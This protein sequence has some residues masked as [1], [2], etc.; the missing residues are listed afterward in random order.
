MSID[1]ISIKKLWSQSAGLCAFPECKE[2]CVKFLDKGSYII[3]EMAHV[4]ARKED[5]PRG[6]AGG[7]EDNYENLILL[8]PTH[9]TMIDKS[10]AGTFTVDQIHLWKKEHELFVKQRL[11]IPLLRNKQELLNYIAKKLIENKS[12]WQQYGPESETAILNPFSNLSEYWDFIKL[13]K[14][15]PNNSMIKNAI[16]TYESFFNAEEYLIS[17][18]FIIH[19]DAFENNAYVRTEHYPR[20]PTAFEE[21]INGKK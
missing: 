3:G 11:E 20:F 8:C 16:Q 12:L 13:Q 6:V 10:P 5:G 18:N 2:N 4:I 14:V 21:L 9:H 17:Y 7:G 19:A 15:I 1:D